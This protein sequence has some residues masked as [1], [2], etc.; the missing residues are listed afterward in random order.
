M[1]TLAVGVVKARVVVL[2]ES[3]ALKTDEA[4]PWMVMV[5]A[6]ELPIETAPVEV[7]VFIL[8]AKLDEALIE[9]VAPRTVA[10]RLAVSS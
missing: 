8:V 3:V 2:P 6:A 4:L 10:P 9:V 1:V 5:P 7:P